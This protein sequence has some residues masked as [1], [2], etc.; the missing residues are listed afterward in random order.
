MDSLVQK[1]IE[2]KES[3]K[4]W[5]RTKR[6]EYKRELEEIEA[7]LA[8]NY[9]SMV[10][11]S[12]IGQFRKEYKDLEERKMKILIIEEETWRQIS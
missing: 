12:F 3:V 6:K 7:R 9:D 8:S 5:E 10:T 1:L 4:D 11:Q 2:L